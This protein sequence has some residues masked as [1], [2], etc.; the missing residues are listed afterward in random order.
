MKT[1]GKTIAIAAVVSALSFPA[2]AIPVFAMTP[3][4]P[5]SNG[6]QS[7][8]M[9]QSGAQEA[10]RMVPAKAMLSKAL[11]S[12]KDQP[13]STIEAKLRSKV[14]LSDGTVLPSNTILMGRVT[15]DDMHQGGMAKLALRFTHAQ[16]KDGK[17]VPIKATIIDI[18]T[19]GSLAT[20]NVT[21]GFDDNAPNSWTE[22][23]L[24]VD[25]V[26]VISGVDLH[27]RIASKNSAVF[28]STKKHDVKLPRGSELQLAIA[29]AMN[30]A[31]S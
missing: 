5:A 19:P 6:L 2:F 16:L 29:P 31:N 11:D 28:V 30:A 15:T 13:N 9:S 21:G 4:S 23:T 3:S 8:S 10:A 24:A 14:T 27:S 18:L 12:T 26:G 20:G 25:Q 17:V 22:K 7:S 1:Y